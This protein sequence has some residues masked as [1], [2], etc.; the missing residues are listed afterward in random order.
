MRRAT[1]GGGNA[2]AR[3]NDSQYE[4]Q[5]KLAQ[6]YKPKAG[7]Y[8]A[9]RAPTDTWNLWH[10]AHIDPLF[11]HLIEDYVALGGYS[12]LAKALSKM[13]PEAVLDELQTRVR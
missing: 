10:E 12:A 1:G 13:S 11:Q 3:V 6:A 7:L 5:I 8:V 4:N 9:P 2:P